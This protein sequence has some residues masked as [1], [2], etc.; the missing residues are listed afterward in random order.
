[1]IEIT[2]ANNFLNG[3]SIHEDSYKIGFSCN[4]CI[5]VDTSS[6][7][8]STDANLALGRVRKVTFRGTSIP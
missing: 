5:L 7:R 4:D 2:I 6:L 3:L 1:M 8:P